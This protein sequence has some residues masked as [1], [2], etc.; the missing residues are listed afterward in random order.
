MKTAKFA[1]FLT[2]SS[3]LLAAC[4]GLKSDPNIGL[5]P[6][7]HQ[8]EDVNI[9]D[10]TPAPLRAEVKLF[11]PISQE[12]AVAI[13]SDFD[14]YHQWV[15]PP[16]EKVEVDNSGTSNGQFGAGTKV[17]YKAGESDVIEYYDEDLA[18]IARPLWGVND[19]KNHRGVVLV[20]EHENGS[21]IHM[22]RY[23][24]PKGVKG[25]FMSK[26]MPIFMEK[27]AKNLAEQYNGKVL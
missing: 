3:V 19:F 25:W 18:M 26:M 23:F 22:R 10:F 24:E 7:T 12:E 4:S 2:L 20:S 8:L 27:S 15:S 9:R 1:L 6:S 17:S 11:L 14:N 13:V 16:P 21:I 5:S